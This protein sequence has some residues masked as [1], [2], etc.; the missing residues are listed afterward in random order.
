MALNICMD[1]FRVV[2]LKPI[3]TTNDDRNILETLNFADKSAE[4][5]IEEKETY[6]KVNQRSLFR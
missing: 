3:I 2:K 6:G 4:E 5:K 1:H